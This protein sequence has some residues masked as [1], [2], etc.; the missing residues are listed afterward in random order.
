MDSELMMFYNVENFYPPNQANV[1]SFGLYNWDEYKYSQKIRKISNVFR[2]IEEDFG[3]LPSIIGL[4]EI[5]AESVLEDLTNDNSPIHNYEIIYQ[6]SQDSRGLSVAIL[7]DKCKYTLAKSQILKFQLDDSLEFDTRDILHAEFLFEENKFH[8]FVLHLPSKRNRD[9]KK[10]KRDYILEKLHETV[11]DLV[12]KKE[13][14]V[15]MGDFNDNP[16]AEAIQRLCFDRNQQPILTNPFEALYEKQQFTTYHGKTGVCFD[17]IL[18]T[19]DSLKATFNIQTIVPEI[20]TNMRLRNKSSKNSH[21]PLR[22]YSG[23]RYIGGWSDHFPVVVRFG[24]QQ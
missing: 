22:T 1:S 23:S 3:Q 13:A 17:Q 7:F 24:K 19:E 5:G 9:I 20:Y 21:F 14:I 11:Q 4:A 18:F 16:D 8:V 2:Y 12:E 10:E 15:L 6:Q